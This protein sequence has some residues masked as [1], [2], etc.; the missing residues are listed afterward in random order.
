MKI[1]CVNKYKGLETCLAPRQ[2]S[3]NDIYYDDDVANCGTH[4]KYAF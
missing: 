3:G 2:A 4:L 1:K